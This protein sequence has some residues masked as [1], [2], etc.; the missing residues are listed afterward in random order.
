MTGVLST[1]NILLLPGKQVRLRDR[2]G[3]ANW[4][5]ELLHDG[6]E[7]SE[8]FAFGLTAEQLIGVHDAL[9]PRLPS[10][11]KN[12]NTMEV[13][14]E[15]AGLIELPVSFSAAARAGLHDEYPVADEL[16]GLS[17]GTALAAVLRPAGL[18]FYPRDSG[19]S[20]LIVASSEYEQAWPIGWPP[21]KKPR[22]VAPV[23]FRKLEIEVDDTP[24][25][26]VVQSL[27]QRMEMPIVFD[28]NG[29][30]RQRIKPAEIRIVIPKQRTFYKRALDLALRQ[31]KLRAELRVDEDER[32]FIWASPSRVNADIE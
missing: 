17:S 20:L 26:D 2:A 13:V 31:A 10:S 12:R 8:K 29:M 24:L 16:A 32:P 19:K 28:Q 4:F 18:V 7:V 21:E 1:Q 27:R 22:D 5:D 9:R 30:A 25:S 23:F 3:L 6:D 11:T 15:L 14:D